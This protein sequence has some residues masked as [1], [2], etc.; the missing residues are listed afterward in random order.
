MKKQLTAETQTQTVN[1]KKPGGQ[2]ARKALR[3]KID[4]NNESLSK[5]IDIQSVSSQFD[6]LLALKEQIGIDSIHQAFDSKDLQEMNISFQDFQKLSQERIE[7]QI[8]QEKAEKSKTKNQK[9]RMRKKEKK[10][11]EREL[12]MNEEPKDQEEPKE[13]ER[14]SLKN[15]DTITNSSS[16]KHLIQNDQIQMVSTHQTDGVHKDDK[17]ANSR[18]SSFSFD[19]EFEESLLMF[20]QRLDLIY[21][22][23]QYELLGN[24]NNRL[25][26]NVSQD[27][28]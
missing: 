26:P 23:P 1:S 17:S 16:I 28:L 3:Q 22:H 14:K 6:A 27:W 19:Q 11:E 18:S 9:K 4:D 15:I 12:K 5:D 10:K 2:T 7:Q 24:S 13:Q 20:R 21:T 25:I 8:A